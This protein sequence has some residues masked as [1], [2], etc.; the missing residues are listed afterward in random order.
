M[1]G[2]VTF[3]LNPT[4]DKSAGVNRLVPER[5]LRCDPPRFDPGGGGI[6]ISRAI[7]RLGGQTLPVF[8]AGG[9]TGAYLQELL[10]AEGL[11]CRTFP[12]KGMNRQNLAVYDR[13]GGQQYRFGMPGPELSEQEWRKCLNVIQD[14][15]PK[16]DILAA[17]GSLPQRLFN[18][19]NPKRM[20]LQCPNG[21]GG[22]APAQMI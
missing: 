11:E 1:S 12:I 22:G 10:K 18:L 9:H 2:I 4:I 7:K 20:G 8:P 21:P 3:T 16:A 15:H 19:L 17:S 5:K 6:N 13:A 14:L